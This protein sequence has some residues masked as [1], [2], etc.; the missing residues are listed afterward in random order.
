MGESLLLCVLAAINAAPVPSIPANQAPP[1]RLVKPDVSLVVMKAAP[2][3]VSGC[4]YRI[5]FR[6]GKPLPAEVAWEGDSRLL[7]T[8]LQTPWIFHDRYLVTLS[9]S[10][11][12]LQ[13]R[14]TLNS[15]EHG[16]VQQIDEKKVTYTV[17]Q[18]GECDVFTFE[19]AT[20][21]RTYVGKGL[22]ENDQK[23]YSDLPLVLQR[24]SPDK[25]KIV[26]WKDDELTL[27]R[28]TEK[29]K[30]LGK[31]FTMKSDYPEW[32]RIGFPILW[33]D[34][35]QFL[36]QRENGKLA[37]VDLAGQVTALL[38]IK[39]VPKV[40]VTSLERDR[41]DRIIYAAYPQHFRIDLAKKTAEETEWEDFGHGFEA[42]YESKGRLC[43]KLRHDG[44]EI[45]QLTTWPEH[46]K[47]APGYFAMTTEEANGPY[48][49]SKCK[50]LVWSATTGEWTAFEYKLSDPYSVVGWIK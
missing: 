14:K 35:E 30:S 11:I 49:G 29:P 20:G 37:V 7:R 3:S 19:Y 15:E 10:V 42:S 28:D 6:N 32:T 24:F 41:F 4:V 34:S 1:P 40:V 17:A 9:G 39:G 45:G 33:L 50:V 8:F 27:Y 47:T 13:D 46:A 38:T 5:G 2:D 36:T 16:R 21:K 43:R 31:G 25:R 22:E 26:V 18:Q 23:W 44:K 12:D 48:G